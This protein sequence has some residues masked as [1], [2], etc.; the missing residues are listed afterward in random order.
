MRMGSEKMK[1]YRWVGEI[2]YFFSFGVKL[3]KSQSQS[4]HWLNI[5]LRFTFWL[6]VNSNSVQT[7]QYQTFFV[8]SNVDQRRYVVFA[9]AQTRSRRNSAGWSATEGHRAILEQF[10]DSRSSECS[11]GNSCGICWRLRLLQLHQRSKSQEIRS[12]DCNCWRD[13]ASQMIKNDS[14]VDGWTKTK[15]IRSELL[16]DSQN[17]TLIL[18]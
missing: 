4:E 8:R 1:T 16:T 5:K 14:T 17:W 18:N 7:L 13:P 11:E 6:F 3:G 15:R 12:N 9:S 10:Y 2:G